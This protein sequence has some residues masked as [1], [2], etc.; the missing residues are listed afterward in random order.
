MISHQKATPPLEVGA[1]SSGARTRG[2]MVCFTFLGQ[3]FL[4]CSLLASL[5]RE[6]LT[7]EDNRRVRKKSYWLEN[8]VDTKIW[9]CVISCMSAC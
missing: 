9:K 3:M 8:M 1:A 5:W 6:V 7:R 4:M 2:C